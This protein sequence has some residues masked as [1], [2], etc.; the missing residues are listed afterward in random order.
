MK[1]I[2]ICGEQNISNLE[3]EVVLHNHPKVSMASVVAKPDEHWGEVPCT[4]IELKKDDQPSHVELRQHC[5]ASLV[6]FKVRRFLIFSDLPK[7]ATGK[8]AESNLED[9][10]KLP[11]KFS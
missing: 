7:T 2:I 9:K 3:I 6:R 8:S 11:R 5:R 1:G 10:P 4:F